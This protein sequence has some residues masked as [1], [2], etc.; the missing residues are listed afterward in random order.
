MTTLEASKTEH[1]ASDLGD[2]GNSS[3]PR[4]NFGS[5]PLICLWPHIRL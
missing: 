3:R 4:R 5:W 1:P 2:C